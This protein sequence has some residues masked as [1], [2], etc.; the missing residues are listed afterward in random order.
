MR[1]VFGVALAGL[2]A[3]LIVGALLCRFYLPGQVVKFPLN[4]YD[5]SRLSGT[6]VS[7]FSPQTG[8]EVNGATVRAVSTTQGDV[9]AGNSSTAVWNNITGVFDVTSSPQVAIG[10]STERL[11]FDRRTG[12]LMNCCG[13]E[14]G[15]ARPQFAGQ[16]YV[17]PI[18]TQQQNYQVFNKS[19]L[20]A[21]PFNFTGTSTVDGLSVDVFVQPINNV[22]VGQ[23][24]TLPGSLVGS[25]QPTVQLPQ[26]LTATNTYYVD[27]AT[28]APVKEVEAENQTL[29][30]PV[31]GA[32]ALVLFN[33][34]LTSTPQSVTAS[35]NTAR[36]Y[37]TEINWLEVIGPIIGLLLGLVLLIVGI[38]LINSYR[39]EYEYEEDDEVVGAQA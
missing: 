4:E 12:A 28:G 34:T 2:G 8:A 29:Q 24:V 9:A 10:Y 33:G 32:T 22:Q 38:L 37:D 16:G 31:T 5:V 19:T 14:V 35:V 39:D 15:T 1:R 18:G 27:P 20:K 17:W 25:S 30:D 7:Y 36:H 26:Y 23:P 6:N 13:A 11:A 3:F 21:E